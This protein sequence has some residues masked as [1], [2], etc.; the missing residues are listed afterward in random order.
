MT[1]FGHVLAVISVSLLRC[2]F[3]ATGEA[4]MTAKLSK[5][6]LGDCSINRRLT[7]TERMINDA[8]DFWKPPT[9]FR[10]DLLTPRDGL[11]SAPRMVSRP[12]GYPRSIYQPAQ[13]A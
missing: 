7:N 3:A 1:S 5:P 12:V 8:A 13:A 4:I 6:M 2:S 10:S 9:S 11:F